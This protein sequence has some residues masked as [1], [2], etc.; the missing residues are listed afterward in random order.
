MA[1]IKGTYTATKSGVLGYC[2]GDTRWL[3][4][5]AGT[6]HR[7][8]YGTDAA[9]R[10]FQLQADGTYANDVY[11][12]TPDQ[13]IAQAA[14]TCDWYVLRHVPAGTFCGE[15]RP[16]STQCLGP[17]VEAL[18]RTKA[19]ACVKQHRGSDCK[20]SVVQIKQGDTYSKV[21]PATPEPTYSWS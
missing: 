13:P 10:N 20:V 12:F 1:L 15:K 9:G 7:N 4:S 5:T 2:S 11:V 14:P 3:D 19:I 8:H 21:T 6:T 17:Y 16:A 18:A